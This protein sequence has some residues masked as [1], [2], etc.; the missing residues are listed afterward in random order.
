M[1]VIVQKSIELGKG[2]TLGEFTS[3]LEQA[4]RAHVAKKLNLPGPTREKPYPGWGCYSCEIMSSSIVVNVYQDGPTPSKYYAFT[5][6]RDEKTGVFT[7]GDTVEVER[8]TVYRPKATI[9]QTLKRAVVANAPRDSFWEASA[10]EEALVQTTKSAVVESEHDKT[11]PNAAFAHVQKGAARQFAHHEA[12]ATSATENSSLNVLA[13]R[14]ALASVGDSNLDA[15]SVAKAKS[16]LEAHA[17]AWLS[18][19]SDIVTKNINYL[20]SLDRIIARNTMGKS[21]DGA[22]WIRK[23]F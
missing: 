8:A 15:E 18:A 16:H 19:R 13:L 6:T 3:A 14:N 22:L 5:Y 4:A 9:A 7:F 10:R 23:N 21:A 17:R 12:T 1:Q 2:E 20:E 11:L